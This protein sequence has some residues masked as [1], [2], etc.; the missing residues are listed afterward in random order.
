MITSEKQD[1]QT[2]SYFCQLQTQRGNVS[3]ALGRGGYYI[4]TYYKI[5]IYNN[6][7]H[8]NKMKEQIRTWHKRKRWRKVQTVVCVHIFKSCKQ[9]AA[10]GVATYSWGFYARQTV[11]EVEKAMSPF[12]SWRDYSNICWIY[13]KICFKF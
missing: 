13:F 12:A 11:D 7:L 4:I 1:K 8:K 5:A 2:G 3:V 10:S 6:A 9:K